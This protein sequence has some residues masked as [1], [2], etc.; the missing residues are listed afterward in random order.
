MIKNSEEL[1]EKIAEN[2]RYRSIISRR[3][4]DAVGDELDRIIENM[5]D[6]DILDVLSSGKSYGQDYRAYI[7]ENPKERAQMISN[8][9][10]AL[11][12]VG[13]FTGVAANLP[14]V[15]GANDDEIN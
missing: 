4:N 2:T 6:D 10:R 9:K 1:N 3:N 15:Y 7:E 5:S 12:K 8:I 14:K 13:V 11:I